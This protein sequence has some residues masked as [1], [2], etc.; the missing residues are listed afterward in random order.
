MVWSEF[1]NELFSKCL[2]HCILAILVTITIVIF[3][4]LC[5]GGVLGMDYLVDKQAQAKKK[6]KTIM[7]DEKRMEIN[8]EFER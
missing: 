8:D 7:S 4:L 6:T 5:V 2:Q 1:W 3:L